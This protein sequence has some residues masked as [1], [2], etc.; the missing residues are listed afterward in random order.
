MDCNIKEFIEYLR[1]IGNRIYSYTSFIDTFVEMCQN[2]ETGDDLLKISAEYSEI[3][4][5]TMIPIQGIYNRYIGW[6]LPSEK[7]C[8]L[9]VSTWKQFPN[10]KIVDIGGGTG[11]FCKVFNHLGIPENKLLAVDLSNPS[12]CSSESKNFWPIH[13]EDDFKVDPN[14][15]LFIAWGVTKSHRIIDDYVERGGHC[16][17][18]LGELGGNITTDPEM[19]IENPEWNVEIHEVPGPASLW[20]ERLSISKRK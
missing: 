10:S 5:N 20:F 3:F 2:A 9:V 11:L 7:A 12:H 18:I 17:I 19:L 13:R 1:E 8:T 14:D 16:V 4:Y 6:A 15:I